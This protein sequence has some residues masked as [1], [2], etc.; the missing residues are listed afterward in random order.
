MTSPE[1]ALADGR[2]RGLRHYLYGGVPHVLYDLPAPFEERFRGVN[3]AGSE[4]PPLRVLTEPESVAMVHRIR[5]AKPDIVRVALGTPGHDHFVAEC[6]GRL[7]RTL[8]AVGAALDFYVGHK[9]QA[10]TWMQRAGLE[11]LFRFVTEPQRLWGGHLIGNPVF[12]LGVGR[13]V[14][15]GRCGS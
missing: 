7:Q 14:L 10:P 13:A 2:A 11:W 3:T 12:L 1:A 4:S 5:A 15:T 6:A 8:V 9:R